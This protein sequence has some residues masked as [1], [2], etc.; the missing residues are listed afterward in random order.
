MNRVNK[1]DVPRGQLVAGSEESQF[2]TIFALS[3]ATRRARLNEMD[4]AKWIFQR[5]AEARHHGITASRHHGI[6]ASRRLLTFTC[7]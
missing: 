1:S 2:K 6:T 5:W 3:L 7:V 4:V